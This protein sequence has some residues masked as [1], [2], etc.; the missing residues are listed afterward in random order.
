MA[1]LVSLAGAQTVAKPFRIELGAYF[2]AYRG[3]DFGKDLGGQVGVG[4]A[5]WGRNGLEL[6]GMV[7]TGFHAVLFG[8]GEFSG[9]SDGSLTFNAYT[10]EARH[11]EA[12]S[13]FFEGLGLGYG[14]AEVDSPGT[15]GG[16]GVVV[17]AEV[18][19]DLTSAVFLSARYQFSDRDVLR[20][21]M[22]SLGFRF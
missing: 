12:R 15:G 2:P 10:L 16:S 14:H 21:A 9:A 11:H 20:G 17:G 5:F 1:A 8:T 4:Y 18:G 6:S 22:V 7:R 3:S 19:V 13:R